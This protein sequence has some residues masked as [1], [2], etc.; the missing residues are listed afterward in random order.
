MEFKELPLS[1][2]TLKAIEKMGFTEP[3]PIQEK[4]IPLLLETQRDVAGLAQTGTGKTAAFGLPLIEKIDTSSR[5]IQ[6]LVLCPTRGTLSP[7]QQRDGAFLQVHKG[8][9]SCPR[10]RR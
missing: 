3:T 9:R 4:V 10:L 2:S 5:D 8:S 1:E 7:D 6:G